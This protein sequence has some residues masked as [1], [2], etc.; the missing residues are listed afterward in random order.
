MN[1][2]SPVFLNSQ[3]VDVNDLAR[4][5]QQHAGLDDYPLAADVSRNVVIYDAARLTA[6]IV[7]Q[8]QAVLAELHQ[9]LAD[10]PGVLVIRQGFTDAAV[11]DRQT[12]VFEALLAEE[13][14]I[15]VVADHFAA[16]GANGRLWNAL[17]KV[18]LHS[19]DAFVEY[20][21]NP[22]LGLVAEA[23]L[24]ISW[25]LTAQVNIVRPGG[26]AQ[27]PHR[28]YHLGFQT[29]QVAEQFPLVVHRLSRHLTLQGAVAHSDMPVESGPTLLLPFSHQYDL[30]YLAWRH[31]EVIDYFHQHAVQ[32]P[33]NKGDLLF[34][35]PALLHAA[36][37]NH[38]LSHQRVANLLQISSAFG[39]PMETV[40][41]EAMMQAVYP[42]LIAAV[43]DKIIDETGMAAVIAATAD[44]YSFPTNLDRDPPL[45]GLAPET[46][47]QLMARAVSAQ[48]SSAA[49][50]ELVE[51]YRYKR[52]A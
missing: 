35:N 9:V 31:P 26:K 38:T 14:K 12:A 5:C 34:F 24:G 40:N 3:D 23:W 17:Q 13:A 6:A 1:H 20:Y 45:Y 22:L 30:G 16:A 25:Q 47:Q 2:P 27:Q 15:G 36:G 21:A 43:A 4:L 42:A 44:G 51:A 8:R 37:N 39:R 28:D 7:E 10:G 18:A 49:F 46:G 33:L 48:L 41:R 19:P 11:L 50:N 29:N 52:Q 32:L